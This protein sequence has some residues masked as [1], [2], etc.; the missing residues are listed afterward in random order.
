MAETG[1]ITDANGNFRTTLAPGTYQARAE[2]NGYVNLPMAPP[3]VT[4]TSGETTKGVT[5]KLNKHG[6]ISGRVLDEDGEPLAH[7]QVQALKWTM[8]GVN[9]QRS[10]MPNGFAT[11]NDLGEYRMFGLPPGKYYVSAQSN[12]NMERGARVRSR[13]IYT[14]TYL[15]GVTEVS[16]AQAVEITPGL[17][18]QGTDIRLLKVNVVQVSGKVNGLP[19]VGAADRRGGMNV[20][21]LARNSPTS[22]MPG[23]RNFAEVTPQGDFEIQNVPSGSYILTTTSF[24]PSDSKRSGHL[25]LDVG[26]R[27]VT[28]V[29]LNLEPSFSLN[30]QIRAE[31]EPAL[32]N[33]SIYLQARNFGPT[34]MMAS[35]GRPDAQG[36]LSI[37]NLS[38]DVYQLRANGL[39]AGYYVKSIQL[40]NVESKDTVDLSAGAAGDLVITL[41]KGTAEVTGIVMGKDQKPAVGVQV[42]LLKATGETARTGTT[43]AQGRYTIGEIPPGDYRLTPISEGEI[44]DPDIM[45]KLA[46][47]AE[48]ITL[49]RSA[50]ETRKLELK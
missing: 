6:V 29:T 17:T 40:G 18:R 26:D 43:D 42:I 31:G 19:A 33:M 28:G 14:T 1:F 25:S 11:T 23:P 39:P 36:K 3:S 47:T 30:A 8:T 10:L 32:S 16:A 13:R 50:K 27:D 9:G 34:T 45:D 15:P 48:K 7:A 46:T 44:N 24:G 35:Y 12:N 41:E 21:L 2:R 38:S 22:F 20:M 49:A 37:A 5:I 4:V